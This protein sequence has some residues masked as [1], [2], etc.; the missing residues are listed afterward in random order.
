MRYAMTVTFCVFVPSIISFLMVARL[1][2]RD[3][4]AAEKR[5]IALARNQ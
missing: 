3:W 1:L 4:A 2:P 5:N